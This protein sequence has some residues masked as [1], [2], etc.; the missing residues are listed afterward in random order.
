MQ[1]ED[2]AFPTAA[3]KEK[4]E[5]NRARVFAKKGAYI[6]AVN[7]PFPEA[8]L[9]GDPP[10]SAQAVLGCGGMSFEAVSLGGGSYDY[11]NPSVSYIPCVQKN[12]RAEVGTIGFHDSQYKHVSGLLVASGNPFDSIKYDRPAIEFLHNPKATNPLPRKWLPVGNEYWVADNRF[13]SRNYGYPRRPMSASEQTGRDH[14]RSGSGHN[15]CAESG[16]H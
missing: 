10:L 9:C 5:A 13:K 6:V 2:S 16:G 15:R 3:L 14:G 8:W 1:G 7:L 12:N 11:R 4:S